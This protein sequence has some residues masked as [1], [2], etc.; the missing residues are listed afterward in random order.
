MDYSIEELSEY[1]KYL[2]TIDKV[3]E[4]YF[5]DQKEY[6]FC[7]KGCSHCCETGQYPYTELEYKFLILGFFSLPQEE[8]QKIISRIQTLKREYNQTSDKKNFTYR[9][10][11]L[12]EN[13]LCSVYEYRGMICR[14]FGLLTLLS[15]NQCAIPFCHK[16]GLNYSNVYDPIKKGIDFKKVEELNYKN[17]PYARKTNIKSLMSPDLFV[18]EPLNFGETKALIDWFY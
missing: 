10:P 7:Q 8:R 9:C 17:K 4:K 2:N 14:S 1:K 13:G 18:G 15:N 12:N 6:I 5:E 3:L 16:F 11:F